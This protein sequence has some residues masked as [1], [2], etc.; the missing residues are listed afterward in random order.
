VAGITQLGFVR[1]EKVSSVSLSIAGDLEGWLAAIQQLS[2][3]SSRE[4]LLGTNSCGALRL[5]MLT[6]AMT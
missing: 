1:P 3:S 5:P 6:A 2:P 4:I